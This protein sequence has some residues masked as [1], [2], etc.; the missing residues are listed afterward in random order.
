[1]KINRVWIPLL[2]CIVLLNVTGCGL[3]P[4][5]PEEQLTWDTP[6]E[7]FEA[8][9]I[10]AANRQYAGEL[11]CYPPE[12]RG[13]LRSIYIRCQRFDN[14]LAQL[15]DDAIAHDDAEALATWDRWTNQVDVN[16]SGGLDHYDFASAVYVEQGDFMIP[17]WDGESRFHLAAVRWSDDRWYLYPEDPEAYF[18]EWIPLGRSYMDYFWSELLKEE[19][20][21]IR[22]RKAR[23]QAARDEGEME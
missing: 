8:Y 3:T 17:T 14:K 23:E 12:H 6:Q 11:S 4:L 1:M 21:V 20:E 19:R 16:G 2:A 10:Y 13:E 9:T 15:R 7:L 22:A 18:Y 5:T